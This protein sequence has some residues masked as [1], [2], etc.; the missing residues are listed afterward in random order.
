[1][2]STETLDL[3]DELLAL[4][5]LPFTDHCLNICDLAFFSLY[6]TDPAFGKCSVSL[7]ECDSIN[8]N[9]RCMRSF[10]WRATPSNRCGCP[11]TQLP[12]MLGAIL[13]LCVLALSSG[14]FYHGYAY[15]PEIQISQSWPLDIF[16]V[17]Y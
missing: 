13:G 9:Y 4:F 10:T 14:P 15:L 1:M 11:E 12:P 17:Y 3:L 2:T 16:F 8:L 5:L 7:I 6:V